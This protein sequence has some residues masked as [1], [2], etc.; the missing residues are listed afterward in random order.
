VTSASCCRS[1]LV[2]S[3]QRPPQG[4]NEPMPDAM[5]EER[6]ALLEIVELPSSAHELCFRVHGDVD[7]VR[8]VI[9]NGGARE[10]ES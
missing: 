5:L 10:R 6:D 1:R 4:A 3:T 7:G 9:D 2:A 8:D